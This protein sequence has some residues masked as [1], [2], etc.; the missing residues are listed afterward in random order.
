VRA[1]SRL[2]APAAGSTTPR[3]RGGDGGNLAMTEC[4]SAQAMKKQGLKTTRVF[5]NL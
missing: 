5:A 1:E 4:L 3:Q 2:A